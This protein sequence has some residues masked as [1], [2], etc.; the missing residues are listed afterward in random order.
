MST[1]HSPA[2]PS[3]RRLT[4]TVTET[5][6]VALPPIDVFDFTQ[7]YDRRPEWDRYVT[8]AEIASY[9]PRRVTVRVGGVGRYT[10]EYR[11]FRRGE[12]TSAQFVEVQ[13][14]WMAG[15]GGSWRYEPVG[16]GTRWT[17]TNTF[18][19]KHPLLSR[20]VAPLVRVLLRRSMRQ[21]MREA[22]Q[23]MH[24]GVRGKPAVAPDA[25]APLATSADLGDRH[26]ELTAQ[27]S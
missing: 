25:A 2:S 3:P 4:V 9:S 14:P 18:E 11:L 19:L 16:D 13:S 5:I 12:R 8:A 24:A 26:Y 6:V 15:G 22:R 17:Q 7:D 27:S 10:V 20:W 21:A 23:L 1:Q